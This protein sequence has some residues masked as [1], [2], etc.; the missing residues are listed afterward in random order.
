[1]LYDYNTFLQ[2]ILYNLEKS[3][4]NLEECLYNLIKAI[5][6]SKFKA[7]GEVFEYIIESY[8]SNAT[9]P[10]H[11]KLKLNYP[12][13]ITDILSPEKI[14]ID[15][16][17]LTHFISDM[18]KQNTLDLIEV[19]V[20]KGQIDKI[21]EILE[22]NNSTLDDT[23]TYDQHTALEE[24][25]K[26]SEL[27]IGVKSGISELDEYIKAY[28]YASNNTLAAPPGSFKCV[29]INNTYIFTDKGLIL[30]R[31]MSDNRKEDTVS[32]CNYS[33]VNKDN[34]KVKTPVFY[35]NG[36][37]PTI[38]LTTKK[39]FEITG[40]PNHPVYCLNKEG[41]LEFIKLGDL[42]K[43]HN[44]IHIP[45]Q[46]PNLFPKTNYDISKFTP[47]TPK[48]HN[49]IHLK[50][51]LNDRKIPKEL[52]IELAE[53][54]GMVVADGYTGSSA[55]GFNLMSDISI[56]PDM[57]EKIVSKCQQVFNITPTFTL[58]KSNKRKSRSKLGTFRRGWKEYLEFI[59][60]LGS[61]LGVAH[62][63]RV[64]FSILQSTKEVQAAFLRG[65]FESDGCSC[66]S[67]KGLT[68]SYV[69]ASK[70]LVKQIQ[71]MLLN[72]N[73]VSTRFIYPSTWTHKGITKTR[74][75]WRL[76]I[77][78]VSCNKF[79]DEI[80]FISNRKR[81][82]GKH[83]TT[84]YGKRYSIPNQ[85]PR[86][87]EVYRHRFPTQNQ[88]SSI[89]GISIDKAKKPLEKIV[90]KGYQLTSKQVWKFSNV[91]EG[92]N[93]TKPKE[94]IELETLASK[95]FLYDEI[96]SIQHNIEGIEVADISVPDGTSF[97][98]N[99]IISHNSTTALSIA[100]NAVKSGFNVIYIS[101]E[102]A[103]RALYF[104][105]MARHGYEMGY[106][107]D[108]GKIKKTLLD[109]NEKKQFEEVVNDFDS[110]K[111]SLQILMGSD[112]QKFSY[113][114]MKQIFQK[115]TPKGEIL[116]LIIVDYLQL[117]KSYNHTKMSP[118]DFMNYVMN[119]L[120]RLSLDLNNKKGSI[121]ITLSQVNREGAKQ[122]AKRGFAT[123]DC[124]AECS[125]LER[126]SSTITVLFSTP[127][128]RLS[129]TT[130]FQLIKNR[131]GEDMPDMTTTMVLPQFFV[132]GANDSF[133]LEDEG[134]ELLGGTE[135]DG[136]EDFDF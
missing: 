66:K 127:N 43:D 74:D 14:S 10:S 82:L 4:D 29:D 65:L 113:L 99:G 57:E 97:N 118:P 85:K 38:R 9:Y 89:K 37:Q 6:S 11:S 122:I 95:G 120:T 42:I 21:S 58:D 28:S 79:Y 22:N 87:E 107:L 125:S 91:L 72:F 27:P 116:D 121:V 73:I 119:S 60:Y 47:K 51:Y 101:L 115:R 55:S 103:R 25:N 35:Y 24:Y 34:K 19:Y 92:R 76:A 110:L 83:R 67:R 84:Q 109:E 133:N 96:K 61:S 63:K 108:A 106:E 123:M 3:N 33:V 100:Y 126:D 81:S 8:R 62:T 68:I 23:E 114:N 49:T 7:F 102:S 112:I 80:N 59:E 75:Y 52:S 5:E 78:S 71:L 54:L 77:N 93:Y 94:L 18:E 117:T 46:V 40:T 26:M 44:N 86:V 12:N 32:S 17:F 98:S 36:F 15:E 53:L 31:D 69:S 136:I 70:E 131:D 30:L 90:Y 111:G 16:E 56:D 41:N 39:G 129:N 105:L 132:A 88:F 50:P 1:M 134:L 128:E 130:R 13:I 2:T 124:L 104:N 135:S 48:N 64:P 20:S 45:I